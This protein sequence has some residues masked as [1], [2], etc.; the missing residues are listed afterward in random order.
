ML[1]DG[2]ADKARAVCVL[3]TDLRIAENDA[4]FA[5]LCGGLDQLKADLY[6]ALDD[7]TATIPDRDCRD[8]P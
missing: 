8:I 5:E 4:E 1:I 6:S 7:F 3:V 2:D